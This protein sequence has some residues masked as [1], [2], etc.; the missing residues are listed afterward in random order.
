MKKLLYSEC[1]FLMMAICGKIR[2]HAFGTHTQARIV[3]LFLDVPPK[4]LWVLEQWNLLGTCHNLAIWT[5]DFEGL[6]IAVLLPVGRNRTHIPVPKDLL[7]LLV[8]WRGFDSRRLVKGLRSW[9]GF[10]IWISHG[11]ILWVI[12]AETSPP[13]TYST[14][15][16]M[17]W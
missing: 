1:I 7:S 5:L 9:C 14:P 12:L 16:S 4:N 10:D 11:P 2:N 8:P 15:L 13:E 3:Q 17:M 6:V